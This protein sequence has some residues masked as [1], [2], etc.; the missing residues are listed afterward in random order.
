MIEQHF[1]VPRA[2]L[3][4]YLPLDCGVVD[5]C[6]AAPYAALLLAL[7]LK[8]RLTSLVLRT[9]NDLAASMWT[10]LPHQFSVS[11]CDKLLRTAAVLC[12]CHLLLLEAPDGDNSV[13]LC[14]QQALL[15]A[16]LAAYAVSA[17][18]K[19]FDEV[20]PL[21]EATLRESGGAEPRWWSAAWWG[22]LSAAVARGE[23][24]QGCASGAA[25]ESSPL[26]AG[27]AW[28]RLHMRVLGQ[29]A[30][31]LST[32]PLRAQSPAD[33]ALQPTLSIAV[34]EPDTG[35][36]RSLCNPGALVARW[37]LLARMM[38]REL[39]ARLPVSAYP[40]CFSAVGS[41]S[42]EKK[43]A[44]LLWQSLSAESSPGA[45]SSGLPEAGRAEAASSNT[46]ARQPL[47]VVDDADSGFCCKT[48]TS[49]EAALTLWPLGGE[50]PAAL[51]PIEPLR[52][53]GNL[54]V[55]TPLQVMHRKGDFVRAV[56]VN[57]LNRCQLAVALSKGVHQ[58]EI[59]DGLPQMVASTP[60]LQDDSSQQGQWAAWGV[61]VRNA[62]HAHQALL[63][64]TDGTSPLSH[65]QPPGIRVHQSHGSDVTARC[66][67]A[68]PKVS[69]PGL[70][71]GVW[72]AEY[73]SDGYSEWLQRY[74]ACRMGLRSC[75]STS[76]AARQ[77]C[78]A[79]SSA[80]R[81]KAVVCMTICE[82]SISPR[83]AV[84]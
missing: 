9:A 26:E 80:R 10:C 30:T 74:L 42:A 31:S 18:L 68:H 75:L 64:G 43:S 77:S 55:S 33:E 63:S 40:V 38:S 73:P 59:V 46:D 82:R 48:E 51:Q 83:R 50:C 29:I 44:G 62:A 39:A 34:P 21:L 3:R 12:G 11:S 60:G 41:G 16:Q 57:A 81:F 36:S 24:T 76:L 13:E 25:S 23:P 22:R 35:L 1:A 5:G 54:R 58:L 79:G 17:S 2:A 66:L 84:A 67:C 14:S 27:Y 20:S 52:R 8:G 71:E 56:C 45:S 4:S 47:E 7:A 69:L 61:G 49:D 32:L 65:S 53:L 6:H 72:R 78:S 28:S 15:S 37:L 19:S 70:R